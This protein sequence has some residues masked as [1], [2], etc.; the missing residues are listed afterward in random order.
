MWRL[1]TTAMSIAFMFLKFFF[2]SFFY[3]YIQTKQKHKIWIVHICLFSHIFFS[4]KSSILVHWKGVKGRS[5]C[6]EWQMLERWTEWETSLINQLLHNDGTL[7]GNGEEREGGRRRMEIDG[8]EKQLRFR[9]DLVFPILLDVE[10]PLPGKVVVL[11]IVSKL[12]L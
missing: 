1:P 3:F 7:C 8:E 12:G 2:L 10:V 9:S 11:V 6:R 5:N 4:W